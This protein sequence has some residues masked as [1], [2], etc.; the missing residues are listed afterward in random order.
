VTIK[1][2]VLALA[3]PENGGTYQ[4]TLS[5]LQAL[6]HTTGLQITLYGD[7]QNPDFAELGYPIHSFSESRAQQLTALIAHRMH[8]RLPDPFISEDVLLAPIY[9]LALLHTSKPF[10]YT[11]HDL[12]ESYFP[13]NFPWWQRIWR[14]QVYA[15]LSGRSRRV[16]CES[17][18]VKMDIARLF[19]VAKERIA[20]IAAPPLRQFVTEEPEDRLKAVQA[21]LK[22][23]DNFLFYPAQ[24][25]L[26]KNHLR[27]LT[28]FREVV[29]EIPDLY[30]VLT[31][32]KRDEYSTVM[33]AVSKFGLSDR[34]RHLGYVEQDD[35]RAIYKLAT[36][37]VMP[38]LFESVS[39]P[40]YEAFQ[41]GTPVVASNILAIPEQVGDAGL[42]FDPRSVASIKDAILRI[43]K[44]PA[45]AR[46]LGKRGQARMSAMTSERYGSQLQVLLN[47]MR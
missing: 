37:L 17:Q 39:I 43:A 45:A 12:Q 9:S 28:A 35:L 22:L 26:H 11:L 14:N 5:M 1:L 18:Y 10:A 7:A 16:I 23:P 15:L 19:G 46:Q 24:F 2:G 44:D 6:Q 27:L 41:A 40:I 36:A 38:S 13:E 33:R 34:V 20:V 47:E 29:T 42:L 3:R 25:W 21:R 4:Y 30:L 8:V 32:K 31:G